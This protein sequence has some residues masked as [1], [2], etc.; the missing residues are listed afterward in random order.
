M[1]PLGYLIFVVFNLSFLSCSSG[2][3]GEKK[4]IGIVNK[5]TDDSSH[6][7]SQSRL[8]VKKKAPLPD[9]IFNVQ[10]I[11]N[12][13]EDEVNK[14]LGN[15]Y[16]AENTINGVRKYYSND[17]ANVEV[18]YISQ[19][20]DWI[21]ILPKYEIPFEKESLKYIKLFPKSKQTY[22]ITNELIMLRGMD[23]YEE[24]AIYSG[25]NALINYYF[26]KTKTPSN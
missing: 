23:Q 8:P 1:K 21:K 5:V 19:K 12:L 14:I 3:D 2:N 22:E 4:K 26:I 20:A 13:K 24:V 9:N 10:S 6:A 18:T 25:D 15:P 17:L 7:E 16:A 11:A